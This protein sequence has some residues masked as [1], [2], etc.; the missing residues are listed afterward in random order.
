MRGYTEF[1]G[2]PKQERA[3]GWCGLYKH[4]GY[5]SLKNVKNHK[6]IEKKCNYFA[7][8]NNHPYWQ[9][10]NKKLSDKKTKKRLL[11]IEETIKH[12]TPEQ[13]AELIYKIILKEL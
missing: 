7:P 9:S 3:V 4:R 12:G 5:L 2:Q 10:R 11:K 1:Q 8:I 6:C 13:I